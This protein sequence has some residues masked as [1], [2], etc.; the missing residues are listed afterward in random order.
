MHC[1]CLCAPP[2]NEMLPLSTFH[3]LA[4]LRFTFRA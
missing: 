3:S 1:G 2:E 4:L